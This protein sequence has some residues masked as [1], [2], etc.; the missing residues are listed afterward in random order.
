MCIRPRSFTAALLALGV[1]AFG[2]VAWAQ[3]DPQARAKAAF[4]QGKEALEKGRFAEALAAY[5]EANLIKPHP[6]MLK[7]MAQVL[8]AM[9]QLPRALSLYRQYLDSG[10]KDADK[11]QEKIT[12]LEKLLAS[13]ATVELQTQPTGA[14][15]WFGAQSGEPLGTTPATLNLP[16]GKV[17]VVFEKPGFQVATRALNISSGKTLKV[18][19]ALNPLMPLLVIRSNPVGAIVLL[20]GKEIGKTPFSQAV[21]GGEHQ[22]ELRKP[23]FAPHLQPI[24][25][26][27]QHTVRTPAIV[28]ATLVAQAAVGTL[29]IDAAAGLEIRVDGQVMGRT[30]LGAP[31]SLAEGLRRLEL[32]SPSGSAHQEMVTITA[33]QVTTTRIELAGTGGDASTSESGGG[34]SGRTWSYIILGTGGA[35][36]LAGGA[37]GA[38]AL[39]ASGELDDCRRAADCQRTSGE[40][41]KAE[42]VRSKAM[43]SDVLIGAGLIVAGVGAAVYM[44]SGEPS[45]ATPSITLVPTSGGAAAVGTVSF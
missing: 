25:L 39:S 3:D 36:V 32:H 21:M 28:E 18:E 17:S 22:L 2:T 40:S 29:V 19:L 16:P 4:A 37:F 10:P 14:H 34:P 43:M 6:V 38:M 42:S 30:P 11:T 9:A 26:T 1:L 20:D 7:N 13:Y 31:L 27:A 33:G 23:G 44:M 41:D 5:E 12:E 15:F 45:A 35:L 24:E 8:E